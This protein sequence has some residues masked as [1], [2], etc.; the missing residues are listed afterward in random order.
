M[1]T[2]EAGYQL[3]LEQLERAEHALAALN[4][5]CPRVSESWR[6]VMAEGWIDQARQLR[7]EIEE[8]TGLATQE[9]AQAE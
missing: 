1:I 4:A 3:A 2:T 7:R 9:E 6:A 5:G 8:Y